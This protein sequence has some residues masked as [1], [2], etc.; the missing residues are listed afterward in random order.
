MKTFEIAAKK[1]KRKNLLKTSLIASGVTL[2]SLVLLHTGLAKITSKNAQ[3]IQDRYETLL[4]ISMPNIDSQMAYFKPTSQYTGFFH[5]DQTKDIAGITVPYET[6]DLAY[7]LRPL[8]EPLHVPR[9]YFDQNDTSLYTYNQGYKIPVFY[10]TKF[11]YRIDD[12]QM[13]LTQDI[14][15]LSQ[16][17]GQAVEMAVTFDKPYTFEEIAELVPAN[18][19]VNWYWI[20][21]TTHFDTS[22][23]LPLGYDG[24]SAPQSYQEVQEEL[25]KL[26]K[27]SGKELEGYLDKRPAP[28][29]ATPE[30]ARQNGYTHFVGKL[31]EAIDKNMIEYTYGMGDQAYHLSEDAKVYL[32]AN[33]DAKT[34]KFAGVIL[35]GRAEDFTDLENQSW[36][37][38]SNIGEHVTI[39]PYHTLDLE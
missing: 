7:A 11:D 26:N 37:F 36:I 30:Q 25:A 35:T 6:L 3:H 34:A 31:Q 19:K 18:L 1:S 12:R 14:T 13:A 16:M 2:T 21:T 17:S 5:V 38:G 15:H 20:G 28:A 24:S 32:A 27:L 22:L 8:Y 4:A 29:E 23:A 33:P 39:Q 9:G 10:N